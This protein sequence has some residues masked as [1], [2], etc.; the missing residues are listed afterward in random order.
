MVTPP[1]KQ[2]EALKRFRVQFESTE[3][4][5]VDVLARDR[6]SAIER[7]EAIDTEFHRRQSDYGSYE[8]T[9]AAEISAEEFSPPDLPASSW[10]ADR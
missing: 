5:T 6:A 3:W 9:D 10:I 2:G 1:K 4:F 7:G 8:A